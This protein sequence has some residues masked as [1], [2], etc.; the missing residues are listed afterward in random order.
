MYIGRLHNQFVATDC[1]Q[2]YLHFHATVTLDT[3]L[4]WLAISGGKAFNV[5]GLL[6]ENLFVPLGIFINNK[7]TTV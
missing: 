7:Y 5:I 3:Q 1:L 2:Q 4:H 6:R